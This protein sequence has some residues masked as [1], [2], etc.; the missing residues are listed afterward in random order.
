VE[1][2]VTGDFA[3]HIM[4]VVFA[5]EKSTKEHKEIAISQD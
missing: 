4:K 5:A 3:R 1:P 2:E